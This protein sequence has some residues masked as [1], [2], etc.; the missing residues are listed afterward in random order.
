MP[1]FIG[2]FPCPQRTAA[3]SLFRTYRLRRGKPT[4]QISKHY[5]LMEQRLE[6]KYCIVSPLVAWL[7]PLIGAFNG[8]G[9]I[10]ALAI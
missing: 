6:I 10:E 5:D 2:N 4:P 8:R 7:A 9:A 1:N 3:G